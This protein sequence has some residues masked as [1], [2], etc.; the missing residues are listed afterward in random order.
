MSKVACGTTGC[1]N[2]ATQ[3]MGNG[4]SRSAVRL[5]VP[6]CD[7]CARKC[8]VPSMW[9][10]PLTSKVFDRVEWIAEGTDECP[11]GSFVDIGRTASIFEV[12]TTK[13]QGEVVRVTWV[14]E[15]GNGVK[16]DTFD[17]G[18]RQV[19]IAMQYDTTVIAFNLIRDAGWS[20]EDIERLVMNGAVIRDEA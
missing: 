15:G 11:L 7:E 3:E 6:T 17:C 4:R 5:W 13:L 2:P 14:D 10:R 20:D 18:D 9:S 1:T 8:R 12:R 16:L 19:R